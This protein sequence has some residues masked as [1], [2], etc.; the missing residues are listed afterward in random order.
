MIK[1][2]ERQILSGPSET[3]L[4][5][6]L[7]WRLNGGGGAKRARRLAQVC[8]RL[9]PKPGPQVSVRLYQRPVQAGRSGGSNDTYPK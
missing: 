5:G 3:Q 6:R 9:F 1:T 8:F 2:G 7:E 4:Q